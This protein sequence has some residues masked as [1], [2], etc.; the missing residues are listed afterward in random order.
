LLFLLKLGFSIKKKTLLNLTI[1]K[2]MPTKEIDIG[3]I[4]CVLKWAVT[5]Y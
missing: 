2:I 1:L 3:T 5:A 4:L